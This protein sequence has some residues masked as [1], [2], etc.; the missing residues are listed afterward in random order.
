MVALVGGRPQ[1]LTLENIL[2]EFLNHRI[3]VVTIRTSYKL[4]KEE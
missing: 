2:T 3:E 1:L 4:I